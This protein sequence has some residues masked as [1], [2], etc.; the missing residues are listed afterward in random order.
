M[1]VQFNSYSALMMH[2]VT[3]A[4]NPS[5][6]HQQGRFIGQIGYGLVA[7]VAAVETVATIALSSLYFFLLPF[8]NTAPYWFARSVEWMKSSTFC[9][10][11]ALTD[12]ALNPFTPIL[13]AD[14]QSARIIIRVGNLNY[15]PPGA[16][17]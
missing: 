3:R 13:V 1:A 16:V 11:W 5:H 7:V 4:R 17:L 14:E 8:S 10:G 12:W 15:L 9:F 2:D 6:H